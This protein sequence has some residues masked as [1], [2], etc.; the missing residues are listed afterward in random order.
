MITQG[1]NDARKYYALT[2]ILPVN[3]AETLR[4]VFRSLERYGGT[5]NAYGA[6]SAVSDENRASIASQTLRTE[7]GI[8]KAALIAVTAQRGNNG[9]S[10]SEALRAFLAQYQELE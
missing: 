8:R 2:K 10:V 4:Q 7:E 9:N 1:L 6:M 3:D 5:Y